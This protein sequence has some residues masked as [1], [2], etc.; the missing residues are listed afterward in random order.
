MTTI[1]RLVPS[2][3]PALEAFLYEHRASSMFL[4]ANVFHSGIEDGPERF[5][6][7]Y[8]GAFNNN[9]LTDV[10]AHY[11]NNNVI[12]QAPTMPV[13]LTQAVVKESGR[14]VNGVI[15]PWGQVKLVE[16]ELE[17]DRSRLGKVVPEYLYCLS[18]DALAVPAPL[19]SGA[20][21]HRR[22]THDDLATL[23][24]WRR[25]YDRITMGYPE[26]AID[27]P[28]NEKM[29]SSLIDDE[30]LWLLEEN[31]LVVAM[32]NFNASLP[33]TVQVGGVFTPEDQRGRGHARAVVAGS[34]L[35]A[36]AGGA[37]AAT[38]FTEMDN[39]PAQ[40]AYE[41]LGF[42]QIGDYGMVVLDP[43]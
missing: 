8:M 35:D 41:S 7:V 12:L 18:L 13:A 17:L 20:V 38:L 15:G 16:P 34:L 6:G 3:R 10:A 1:R 19:A 11:W 39:I 28:L 29:L 31:G 30:N 21:R 32:T 24:P 36:R 43:I 33:H 5:C 22:A 2:D 40:K 4:R 37:T 9:A 26:Q 14:P 23:V 25:V 42:E 27:D